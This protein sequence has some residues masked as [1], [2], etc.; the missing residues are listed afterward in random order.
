MLLRGHRWGNGQQVKVSRVDLGNACSAYVESAEG[1]GTRVESLQRV[2]QV[3]GESEVVVISKYQKVGNCLQI[4]VG[5][6]VMTPEGH[7]WQSLAGRVT[8][9][10]IVK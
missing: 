10:F 7:S 8:L 5:F 2:R 6:P 4:G 9:L 3:V 1:S